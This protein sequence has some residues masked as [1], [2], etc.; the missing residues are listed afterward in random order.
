MNKI[1]GE[2]LAALRIESK[3]KLALGEFLLP[4]IVIL[5]SLVLLIYGNIIGSILIETFV[6][7][8]MFC[9]GFFI[10]VSSEVKCK[11]ILRYHLAYELWLLEET[12]YVN[13]NNLDL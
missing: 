13:Y 5:F 2:D 10:I 4:F 6:L 12:K 9:V 3:Y 7:S 1:S 11:I 8:T